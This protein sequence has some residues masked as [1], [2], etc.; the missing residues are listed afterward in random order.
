M[1]LLF[2]HPMCEKNMPSC[3]KKTNK[4][5]L[6]DVELEEYEALTHLNKQQILRAYQT[7][8]EMEPSYFEESQIAYLTS[9]KALELPE[10]RV[11]PFKDRMFKVFC[12]SGDYMTFEDYLDMMSIFSP[13]ADLLLKIEYA[14]RIYDFTDDDFICCQDIAELLNRLLKSDKLPR[15]DWLKVRDSVLLDADIDQDGAIA[16]TEFVHIAM[17]F[18]D[19]TSTFNIQA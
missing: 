7:F 18:P 14:F 13:K 3:L 8:C 17:K 19:F 1:G 6:D 12:S 15:E 11:N 4:A 5:V 10:F 2:S 16:F 9:E